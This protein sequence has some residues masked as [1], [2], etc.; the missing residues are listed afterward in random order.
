MENYKPTNT[1][2]DVPVLEI[3]ISNGT[4]RLMFGGYFGTN[5]RC[6]PSLRKCYF[7]KKNI[8]FTK[9]MLEQLKLND[10]EREILDKQ[11]ALYLDI[12]NV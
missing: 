4:D 1:R 12:F 3:N 9:E 5:A 10:N 8:D 7:S 6:E 2:I 11:N